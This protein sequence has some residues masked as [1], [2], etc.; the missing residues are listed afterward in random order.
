MKKLFI[1]FLILFIPLIS[2]NTYGAKT[3]GCGLFG[4]GCSDAVEVP[5]AGGGGGGGSIR[6]FD[7]KILDI[8]S[9]INL[10][11]DFDF[12]YFIKGV[13]DFNT[14]V[15]IDFW[16]EK[17]GEII[18]SGSDV[19]FMGS[20][21]E[22]TEAGSLFMPSDIDSGQYKFVIKVSY[23]TIQAEAHRTIELTVFDGEA[24]ID[25]LFDI[26]FLLDE[27]ILTSSD[28]LFAVAIFENFGE[29]ATYVNLTFII[30]DERGNEVYREEDSILVRVEELLRKS[31]EGLNLDPGK[32][33]LILDILYGDNVTDDFEREF[34][35]VGV[36]KM[37][38]CVKTLIG[39]GILFVILLILYIIK[40]VRDK[41]K[42]IIEKKVKVFKKPMKERIKIKKKKPKKKSSKSIHK[43]VARE[44]GN[45]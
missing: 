16:V 9:P 6:Q 35:I 21:E 44:V 14:D 19:I 20:N 27:T 28:D 2:A 11:E 41:T 31:F 17:E 37:N 10:G 5:S 42:K 25:S 29:N 1:V 36:K 33:T 24:T 18:T 40:K 8:E 30:L 12:M 43:K 39:I 13:G 38:W 45:L 32:Y 4:I 22:K 23:G 15:T 7:I 3:Y 26:R 34:E